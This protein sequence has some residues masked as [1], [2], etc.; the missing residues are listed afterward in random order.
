MQNDLTETYKLRLSLTDWAFVFALVCLA[1]IL[2][3]Q[4]MSLWIRPHF[5]FF[6]MA[7]L[8]F[9]Y[10]AYHRLGGLAS[11][12]S[13]IRLAAGVLVSLFCVAAS[14]ESIL[15]SSPW[16]AY[17]AG[18]GLVVAW[19]LLRGN[20]L[21]WPAAVGL[22]SV[23]W[24]TLPFPAGYDDKLIQYLQRQSS[25][26]TSVILDCIGILHL[27][28]G[29]VLELSQKRLFVDEAC[30]GVDSLYALMAICLCLVLW[31][32]QRLF[33][34]VISLSLVPVWASCGNIV[35]LVSIVLGIEWLGIDLSHGTQHTILGL[36]VF[37]GAFSCDFAFI[38]FAGAVFRRKTPV[39]D[40][41][42]ISASA[43]GS[44]A[45]RWGRLPLPVIANAVFI[46]LFLTIGAFSIQIL[47][48]NTLHSYP[49]FDKAS[50]AKVKEVQNLP[51]RLEDWQVEGYQN[52]ERSRESS[53]GQFSN[54]WTYRSSVGPVL[55]STDFPFRGFHLLDICYQGAG[56]RLNTASRQIEQSLG[57][58]DG[59]PS[60]TF[61]PH[62]LD[63]TNDEGKF[64]YVVY[65]IFRLDGTPIQSAAKGVRGL[66]RF[67]QTIL[68]PVSFQIQIMM[69]S[70]ESIDQLQ[71]DIAH[72]NLVTVVN[73]LRR[74]FLSLKEGS[75]AHPD[76]KV[77][78]V[79]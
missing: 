47:S 12:R 75:S 64:A 4:C 65:A 42:S 70:G 14:A 11:C 59:T 3:I 6:P 46:L 1:P 57:G 79:Q 52:L 13:P 26:F 49:T 68:E 48:R 62:V 33:V 40:R 7:W 35:R 58:A 25:Y 36:L 28:E 18:V 22:S 50:L 77:T 53:Q 72:R 30:S 38:Q 31:F 19:L 2:W 51:R 78:N 23:L 27:P 45:E 66:E 41:P 71:R 24:M 55:V 69:E 44:I 76:A 39:F 67:E 16:L 29:N 15:I 34:A 10:F 73:Q 32:R 21:R 61:Y 20:N 63:M 37:A 9:V 17:A 60:E 43:S 74:S 54:V 8:S 56:W 5:Q